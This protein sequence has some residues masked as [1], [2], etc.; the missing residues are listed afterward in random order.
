[1]DDGAPRVDGAMGAKALPIT[2]VIPTKNEERNL[3]RCL[4]AVGPVAEVIVV[5]SGSADGTAEIARRWGA[6]FLNFAWNGHYPKKRNWV[7]QTQRFQTEWVLFLDADE[8]LSEAF[9][10]EIGTAIASRQHDGYWLNYTN[11]FLGRPLRF[12]VPQRKLALF[13][14][15]SGLYE[16]IDES[17]WSPLDMEVHEH[18][19]IAGSLGEIRSPIE[20]NDFRGIDNFI[21]RHR[22]YATW[23]ANR[24]LS[25]ARQT[26]MQT[27]VMTRRQRVKYANIGRWWYPWMYFIYT[28]FLRLGF[29]DGSPGLFYAF[30]KTWYFLTIRLKI[31]ELRR[32][33][34]ASSGR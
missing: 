14:I 34:A 10:N 20:H 24:A 16:K 9:R 19:I 30:Y 3:A 2:V 4:A 21:D 8:I 5:D 32:Q 12:G 13:K 7:L 17:W 31:Q 6:T 33:Q 11:Y 1:M 22:S 25:L 23:E 26:A 15:G 27:A 29:L 28:Y 18:P